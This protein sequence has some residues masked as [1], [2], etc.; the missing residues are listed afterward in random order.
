MRP[1]DSNYNE[2]AETELLDNIMSAKKEKKESAA[3]II[4]AYLV[5]D[6]QDPSNRAVFKA[7]SALYPETWPDHK[8]VA[9]YLQEQGL[10]WVNMDKYGHPGLNMGSIC[11][12]DGQVRGHSRQFGQLSADV[13]EYVERATGP[14]S[15]NDVVSDLCL[16]NRKLKKAMYEALSRIEKEGK[17]SKIDGKNG[18]WKPVFPEPEPMNLLAELSEPINVP[19]PLGI[20]GIARI[21]AGNIILISGSPNAGKTA[22]LLQTVHDFFRSTHISKDICVLTSTKKIRYINSEMSLP[23]LQHRLLESGTS[24][25]TWANYVEFLPC[26]RDFADLIIPDGIN[27]VDFLEVHEDFFL[28][29]KMLAEIHE[30]LSTGVAIV[31][32]QKKPGADYAK[33]GAMTLEKPRLVI[34]LDRTERGSFMCKLMKIKEPTNF[35]LRYD[36][37]QKEFV[38]KPGFIIHELS[39]WHYPPASSKNL[40]KN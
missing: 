25:E 26:S 11:A 2:Q 8:S 18:W 12:P 21:R 27:L 38:F 4:N 28:A 30:K 15:N 29:G 31:A 19:L 14:F 9:V 22:F 40:R 1:V 33:G 5:E 16:N 36:A 20:P 3:K 24:L 32:M 35:K 37:K 6:F 23:E 10:P 39:D 34:N 17:I 7:I 13:R